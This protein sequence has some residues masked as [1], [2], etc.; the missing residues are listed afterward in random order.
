MR[1]H[2]GRRLLT[3][4]TM[5]VAIAVL[6]LQAAS[7]EESTPDNGQV[8]RKVRSLVVVDASGKTVGGVI[9]ADK[10]EVTVA[11]QIGEQFVLIPLKNDG[12][13]IGTLNYQTSDCSGTAFL[14]SP[15]TGAPFPNSAVAPPGKTLYLPDPNAAP[16]TVV[17]KSIFFTFESFIGCD[18]EGGGQVSLEIPAKAV[19]DLNTLFTPPFTVRAADESRQQGPNDRR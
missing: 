15:S 2:S 9:A 3:I 4:V 11:F 8:L 5:I 19:V 17:V 7:A 18:T 10:T 13:V 1:S 6:G 14:D 12:F 16:E